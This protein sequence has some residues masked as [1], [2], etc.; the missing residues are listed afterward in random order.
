MRST[1]R[2]TTFQTEFCIFC[3]ISIFFEFIKLVLRLINQVNM[4]ILT[5]LNS[6]IKKNQYNAKYIYSSTKLQ[7][8]FKTEQIDQQKL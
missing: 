3:L 2:L 4:Q 5:N 1:E 8:P 7:M 6:L